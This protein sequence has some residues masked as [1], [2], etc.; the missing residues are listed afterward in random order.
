MS[1]FKRVALVT[2]ALSLVGGLLGAALGA[3]SMAALRLAMSGL[4]GQDRAPSMV[5]TAAGVGGALGV[6]LSPVAAWTLMRHVPLW[7]AIAET[8]LGTLA[9]TLVGFGTA[10]LTNLG[11][12]GPLGFGVLGFLIAA[13]R[14]RL[15]QRRRVPAAEKAGPS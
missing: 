6:V 9:G 14:L 13:V 3:G 7:R 12:L 1:R 4:H 15:T 5:L 11:I 10:R 8:S 2:L